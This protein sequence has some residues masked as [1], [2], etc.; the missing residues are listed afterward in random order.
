SQKFPIRV[1]GMALMN[2]FLNSKQNGGVDNPNVAS[3]VRGNAVG[4]ATW[5]QSV[6]GFEYDGPGTLWG[7]KVHG[8]L[9]LDF[10]GGTNTPLGHN[11]RIRTADITLDWGSR[12][13]MFGQD[14]PIFAPREPNSLAQVGISPLTASGNLWL[15]APQLRLEQR[16]TLGD[17]TT[18][19]ATAGII[20]TSETSANVPPQF[21]PTL[22]RSRPGLEGRFELSHAARFA[23]APGFHFS[24]TH[25]AST[26]VPSRVASL[27]WLAVPVSRVEWTGFLFAGQNVANFGVGAIRQGFTVLGPAS[28]I[29]IHSKGGWTQ[30]KLRATDRLSFHLLGGLHDDRNEDLRGAGIARN[31][32]AGANFFYRLAPNVIASFETMQVRTTHLGRGNRLNNHYDL[33]IAYLF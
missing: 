25:V 6:L 33:A 17:R 2:A 18:F 28:V 32:S 22:E 9:F 19:R 4:G 23:V 13:I 14:K 8:S 30:V 5:R 10:F 20:Q 27:D 31:R 21:A 29:P 1:T 16:F 12:S 11:P 24:T 26:A 7:G 15:W 3:L